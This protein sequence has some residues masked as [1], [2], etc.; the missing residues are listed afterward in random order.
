[1]QENYWHVLHVYSN[2][3]KRVTQHLAIRGVENYLPLYTERVRWTDRTVVTERALF[4]GYVF[5]RFQ[6]KA[7]FTVIGAPGVVRSLGDQER[8]LV[9]SVVL[10]KIREGLAS[11]CLLRPHPGVSV[12]TR[13][14]VRGGVFEGVEGIVTEFRQQ[15]KVIITLAAVQQSFS[16]E[17]DLD[18]IEHLKPEPVRRTMT[19]TACS[20][21]SY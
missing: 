14:R 16:L 13:V 8:D 2:Y 1:M 19:N 11:G 17:V 7:K 12:G 6:P 9:S 18:D 10:E 20:A 4:P 21:Y 5:A 3:E 15:C